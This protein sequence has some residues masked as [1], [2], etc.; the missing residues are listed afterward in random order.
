MLSGCD[1]PNVVVSLA[2]LLAAFLAG[3]WT[4]YGG[5]SAA[6]ANRRLVDVA[7]DVA[8]ALYTPP[9]GHGQVAVPSRFR[10]VRG[11]VHNLRIGGFRFNVLVSRAN[12]V[13][14]GDVHRSDQLDLIFSGC[15][16]GAP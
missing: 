4:T 9:P 12:S 6:A 10:D 7:P 15:E 16:R 11:E 8:E 14:S 13:R 1:L 5:A 2:A 3:R